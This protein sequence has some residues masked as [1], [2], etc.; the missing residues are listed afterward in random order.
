LDSKYALAKA[1]WKMRFE[2]GTG[3]PVDS[4]N[5]A[6]YILSAACDS[7]QIVFQIDHQDLTKRVQDLGLK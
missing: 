2:R 7:F 3:Q 6:T 5:S 1:V 4:Q